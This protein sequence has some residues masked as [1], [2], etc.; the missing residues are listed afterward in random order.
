MEQSVLPLASFTTRALTY[1]H[2]SG[3]TDI[4]VEQV[5]IQQCCIPLMSPPT[6]RK[7]APLKPEDFLTLEAD[8]IRVFYDKDLQRPDK[9]TIDTQSY[10]FAKALVVKDWRIAI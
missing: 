3:V 9:L 6:V 10:G 8:G 5:N 1:L 2:H 7:G 4:Y